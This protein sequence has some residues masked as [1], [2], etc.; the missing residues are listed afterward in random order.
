MF[1][2]RN[3]ILPSCS[4]LCA[5]LFVLKSGILTIK[6]AVLPTALTMPF[7]KG[8]R[9]TKRKI[10]GGG[11]EVGVILAVSFLFI[12][13]ARLPVN[14]NVLLSHACTVRTTVQSRG[15]SVSNETPLISK[16]MFLPFQNIILEIKQRNFQRFPQKKFERGRPFLPKPM[17]G[18]IWY[19]IREPVFAGFSS[20]NMIS[21][22][23][24][25]FSHLFF[26][27]KPLSLSRSPALKLAIKSHSSPPHTF[28]SPHGAP[29]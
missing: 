2:P 27:L 1:S 25:S 20:P 17:R 3:P 28:P 7:R 13:P 14:V 12:L 29:F 5:Y 26:F 10:E 24:P 4:P 9:Q 23:P 21:T 22:F 18:T 15:K 19:I 6:R 16:A 11:R 8:W